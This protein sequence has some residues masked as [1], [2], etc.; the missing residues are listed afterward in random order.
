MPIN[1]VPGLAIR[2]ARLTAWATW[3]L[4]GAVLVALLAPALPAAA[5]EPDHPSYDSRYHT[6]A[7]MVAEIH[8]AEAAYPG[9]VD[10]MSIG[11]S[12]RGRDIW[13]AKVS[14]NV[15]VDE[16]EPEVLVDAL[17]HARERLT[18]E[19][20]LYLLATLTRDYA[21][22]PAVRAVVDSRE[23]WIIFSVNP[24]GH[25]YDLG[26]NPYRLWRKNRQ[27]TPGSRFVGTDLNRNYDYRWGCCGGSSS[28]PGAWNYRGPAPFSAPET[29]AVR[30]FVNSRVVGGRQQIRVHV[31]LHANGE[32]VLWPYGY[33]TRDVPPDMTLDDHRAFVAIGRRMAARNGYT[34]MQSSDLY[35]TDGD[36]IDWMYGR[37]RIFSFTW[38]LHPR[39]TPSDATD[40]YPPDEIIARETKRNRAALLYTLR[41]A[42]CPYGAIDR[43]R[44]NCGA[45]FDDFEGSQG[46]TGDPDAADTAVAGRWQVANPA[47][48]STDGV[49][50]QLDAATSGRRAL[51]TGAA[52][53]LAP[54]A[55]DLDGATTIRSAPI[56]LRAAVGPLT[57][58][59]YLSHGPDASADDWFRVWVEA[60]DGTRTLVLEESGAADDDAAAWTSARISMD[61][62]AGQTV[63]LVIGAADEGADSLVEAA[64]DDVRIERP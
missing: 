46:W 63:R 57:F 54:A 39:E 36:Q 7:E 1:R 32:Q 12:E 13:V 6:N 24:D 37:H 44:A 27:A 41:V 15:A 11:K 48:T 23:T 53:G 38:E 43:Q 56:V 30:D 58:R 51:V 4:V 47:P 17:H 42:G 45:F 62:W 55:N 29:R 40:H 22:D 2:A 61:T 50:R 34:P 3:P 64:V 20:A 21:S 14:D 5:A 16:A 10:V 28:N 25:V 31:T 9:L 49:P 19:Q 35:R 26:G 59:Y 18:L 33:T 52:A 8:A 60:A